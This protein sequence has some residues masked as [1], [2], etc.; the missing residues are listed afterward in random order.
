MPYNYGGSYPGGGGA[1]AYV[2]SGGYG[3]PSGYK[4]NVSYSGTSGGGLSTDSLEGMVMQQYGHDNLRQMRQ[5]AYSDNASRSRALFGPDIQMPRGWVGGGMSQ[6]EPGYGW[7]A[8]SIGTAGQGGSSGS[9][10]GS[11]GGGGSSALMALLNLK[12]QQ[13]EA[14]KQRQAQLQAMRYGDYLKYGR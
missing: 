9:Y 13:A 1:P 11:S 10:G 12:T 14:D 3:D 7:N 2:S 4:R 8:A 6:M 5:D